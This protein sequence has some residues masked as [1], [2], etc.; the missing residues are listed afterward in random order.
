[1]LN[2]NGKIA[3][4]LDNWY[5]DY[6]ANTQHCELATIGKLD[7]EDVAMAVQKGSSLKNRINNAL[8]AMKTSG[9]FSELRNKWWQG[10][11]TSASDSHRATLVMFVTIVN[12]I[13]LCMTSLC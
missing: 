8:S 3:A 2:S 12:I 10:R 7:V 4:L 1:M 6:F 13:V 11:C 9:E 5:A